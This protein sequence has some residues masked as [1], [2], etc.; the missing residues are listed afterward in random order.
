MRTL[1]PPVIN[2]GRGG[3]LFLLVHLTF[4]LRSSAMVGDAI[5]TT[6]GEGEDLLLFDRPTGARDSI[7]LENL[8]REDL[9]EMRVVGSNAKDLFR[10]SGEETD[11]IDGQQ[12]RSLVSFWFGGTERGDK[13]AEN[14]DGRELKYF[15]EEKG[16]AGVSDTWEGAVDDDTTTL[17]IGPCGVTA[18]DWE[19]MGVMIFHSIQLGQTWGQAVRRKESVWVPEASRHS[20][21]D[22]RI[23][24]L[25]K[26]E[27][28]CNACTRTSLRISHPLPAICCIAPTGSREE[29]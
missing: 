4:T 10:T 6:G 16:G 27:E 12:K 14:V 3:A 21:V 28:V 5:S 7:R 25:I 20:G 17:V 11:D 8:A 2:I 24:A 1:V 9:T 29:V 22:C 13:S 19:M 23:R 26:T 18:V 15:Q